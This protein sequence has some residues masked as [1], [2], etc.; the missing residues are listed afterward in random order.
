[1]TFVHN[2]IK[3]EILF[4]SGSPLS[5]YTT[6]SAIFKSYLGTT[7]RPAAVVVLYQQV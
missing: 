4:Y 1:M 3:T 7:C 2:V 6:Q 5:Y